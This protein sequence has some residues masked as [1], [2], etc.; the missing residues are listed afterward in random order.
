M[1]VLE[2]VPT[3]GFV[4]GEASG[5]GLMGVLLRSKGIDVGTSG[6]SSFRVVS[7]A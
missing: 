1:A 6:D 7:S 2:D 3:P 5:R 4:F